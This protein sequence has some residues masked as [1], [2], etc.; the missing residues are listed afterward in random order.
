M[1]GSDKLEF[2]L[3]KV[4]NSDGQ[5]SH[6]QDMYINNM[7]YRPTELEHI[8]CYDMVTHYEL[9]K[10]TKKKIESSNH[11]V[12]GKTSYNL[13]EEHPSH[14]CMIMVKRKNI[15][16]PCINSINLLPNIADLSI[17]NITTE[18]DILRKRE[19]YAKIILLLFYPYR[20]QDDLILNNSYW[21][22]YIMASDKNM[23]SVKGL[24][25]CQNLQDVCHNLT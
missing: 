8:S 17:N 22:R 25:V 2:K 7:I 10:M 3:K 23:I 14:K 19:Q 9:R 5:Y 13:L 4:K 15:F 24:E 1:D 6:V 21:N 12:E 11:I 20:I 16:I 18:V